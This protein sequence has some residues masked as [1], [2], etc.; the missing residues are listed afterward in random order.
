MNCSDLFHALAIG[1][2]GFG[3]WRLGK[4]LVSFHALAIGDAGL[5][6]REEHGDPRMEQRCPFTHWRLGVAFGPEW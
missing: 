3:H 6:F 2:S 4:A 1:G 5:G